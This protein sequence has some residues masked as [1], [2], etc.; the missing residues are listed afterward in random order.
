MTEAA[1]RSPVTSVTDPQAERADW[2]SSIFGAIGLTALAG[3]WLIVS[4]GLLDYT[5][6]ALPIVWGVLIVLLSVLRLVAAPESRFLAGVS[7]IAGALVC[8]TAVVTSD[9]PGETINMALVGLATIVFS[10]IGYSARSER[11]RP[12]RR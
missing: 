8:I 5:R 9:P 11:A 10:F 6:P 7:A 4:A 1:D 3:V 2:R 12:S